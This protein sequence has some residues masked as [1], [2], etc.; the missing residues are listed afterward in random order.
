MKSSSFLRH[1]SHIFSTFQEPSC[2]FTIVTIGH[3]ILGVTGCG[4]SY[5]EGMF[6]IR[7][8]RGI[9]KITTILQKIIVIHTDAPIC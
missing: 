1:K 3:V 8:K 4:L 2:F 7:L 6:A 5:S 9:P